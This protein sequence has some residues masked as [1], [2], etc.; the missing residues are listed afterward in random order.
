M[1]HDKIIAF[2]LRYPTYFIESISYNYP[3]TKAELQK[4][5]DKVR[6][7]LISQN[8][9]IDWTYDLISEFQ[10][11][12]IWKAFTRNANAFKDMSLI[13]I[14]SD[15]IC[16][17]SSDI[18][19]RRNTIASNEGIRWDMET[20]EKYASK[21]NF[22]VLS[23]NTNVDWSEEL[24]DKYLYKWD[25]IELGMNESVPWTLELFEKYL[26]VDYLNKDYQYEDYI[27]ESL[28][29][30]NKTLVNFDLIEKYKDILNWDSICFNEKL[31]WKEKNLLERWSENIN[32]SCIAGNEFFFQDD[33]NFFQKNYDKW[34][35]DEHSCI[36]S[37][38]WNIAFPWTKE[39]IEIFKDSINW[40]NLCANAG[41]V[42]DIDLINH[43]SKDI[44][45]GGLVPIYD[46]NPIKREKVLVK[47]EQEVKSGLI[48]NQSIPWSID[49][50]EYFETKLTPELMTR[51]KAIW[52]KAFK[53]YVD[54]KLID[55]IIQSINESEI[56]DNTT[57]ISDSQFLSL[58]NIDSTKSYC[59]MNNTYNWEDFQLNWG[60]EFNKV[61]AI[62]YY[63]NTYPKSKQNILKID[64]QNPDELEN[65]QKD[66]LQLIS[67]FTNQI[68]ID[69]FKPYWIPIGRKEFDPLIDLSSPNFTLFNCDYFSSTFWHKTDILKDINEL[70]IDLDGND[71]EIEKLRTRIIERQQRFY[72][73]LIAKLE[74]QD[75]K[76]QD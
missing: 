71:T 73:E 1:P 70:L 42:W 76:N 38:C 20:I 26:N 5:K 46:Y 3:F 13:D 31:P 32:W 39:L 12:I 11:Q 22:E 75:T 29:V 25:F 24:L 44:Q 54:E 59:L 66:W 16:W 19:S 35:T 45:W 67:K 4:Y 62:L 28:I 30:F 47:G 27:V 49:F 10:E 23:E 52:E 64:F 7:G 33:P 65:T 63:I 43:F 17:N 51:N 18:K 68:D 2:L 37:F 61:K 60:K 69:F 53:P 57:V 41:I 72:D 40:N 36:N 6:W 74:S 34:Q 50:L 58:I 8:L 14:F 21:I 48:Q 15:K 55:I 56:N 9:N